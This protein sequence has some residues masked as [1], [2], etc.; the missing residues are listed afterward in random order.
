MKRI[1]LFATLLW[2][3]GASAAPMYPEA[4]F[5]ASTTGG[6]SPWLFVMLAIFI[7]VLFFGG[8]K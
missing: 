4:N 8:K 3:L 5:D 6:G 2:Q 7:L 1:M